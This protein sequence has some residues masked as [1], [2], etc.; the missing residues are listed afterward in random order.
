MGLLRLGVVFGGQS[1]EHEVSIMSARSIVRGL[2]R[3]KYD[4]K[5][6]YV[7][8]DGKWKDATNKMDIFFSPEA[9]EEIDLMSQLANLT[10]DFNIVPD[11]TLDQGLDLVFPAI[12]GRQGEDGSIQGL[13]ELAEI[14]YV[15]AG[16]LG[17]AVSLDKA[18]MRILFKAAGLPLL[19]WLTIN[20]KMWEKDRASIVKEIETKIGYPC[21]VK[22]ANF[23]S[24]VGITKV[25]KSQDL[26]KAIELAL[27]YDRKIVIEKGLEKPREIECS[28]LGNE[29]PIVSIPGE[30]VPANDFYDYEAKYISEQSKL[31]IPAP[32][33]EEHSRLIRELAIKAFKAVDAAGM[34]RVDFFLTTKGEIY[35]NEINTIPGFTKISMYPKLWEATG[36][37]FSSLLDKLVELAHERF[38]RTNFGSSGK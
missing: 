21:F 32:I 37:E 36:I 28:V 4:I 13:L 29:E 26:E 11:P 14:P 25:S 16:I 1:S 10:E 22:P 38:S 27:S 7:T 20:F 5:A 34:G 8:K 23:G 35:L 3:S 18:I 33:N 2:D 31:L 15:G 9:P 17:S 12:H 6:I 19:D 30:I 24:S